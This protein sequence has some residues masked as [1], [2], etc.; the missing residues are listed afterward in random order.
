MGTTDRTAPHGTFVGMSEAAH[1]LL[2]PD[3]VKW[4]GVERHVP[5]RRI[6]APYLRAH[7]RRVADIRRLVP[8]AADGIRLHA[9]IRDGHL[10]MEH[11]SIHGVNDPLEE[12]V[13]WHAT[14]PGLRPPMVAWWMTG[15]LQLS[16][17]TPDAYVTEDEEAER[18]MPGTHHVRRFVELQR[19]RV[20]HGSATNRSAR[21]VRRRLPE[22]PVRW[23][24]ALRLLMLP[25][26]M[27]V[28]PFVLV[29]TWV[30]V[31]RGRMKARPG[32]LLASPLIPVLFVLYWCG[33]RAF[34]ERIERL[35]VQMNEGA[36]QRRAV[37]QLLHD[38]LRGTVR[39]RLR[40]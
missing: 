38:S 11:L 39:S 23:P 19:G 1:V 17:G 27:A 30:E 40:L 32:A 15:L 3:A 8:Q 10:W 25:L 22:D 26:A 33:T 2:L 21:R 37:Q 6:L 7:P 16:R 20:V 4:D 28:P 29:H 12:M 34:Q 36:A 18:T 24:L 13:L 31:L 9:T 35:I 14:F 5:M